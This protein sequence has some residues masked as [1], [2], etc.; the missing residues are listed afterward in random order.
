MTVSLDA[1]RARIRQR[2]I[3]MVELAGQII[4][5]ALYDAAGPAL[6]DG[7]VLQSISAGPDRVTLRLTADTRVTE[8]T[9]VW[10]W[11]TGE[12]EHPFHPHQR[13]DG[14][15]FDEGNWR[16]VLAADDGGA[17]WPG[18]PWYYPGDHRG[19]QC[20]AEI[21]LGTL[22]FDPQGLD[23]Q[24]IIV[25]AF[26]QQILVAPAA[27]QRTTAAA[28]AWWTATLTVEAWQAALRE[29]SAALP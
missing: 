13:L 22:V 26:G 2:G 28:P 24:P 9:T 21:V 29:A 4:V 10:T 7:A 15:V 17:D 27:E 1:I 12:P 3:D 5:A 20:V 16:D 23:A 8:G 11:R 25:S 19:C 18:Q 6:P 14:V